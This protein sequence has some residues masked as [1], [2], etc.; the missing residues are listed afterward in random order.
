ML[1][2]IPEPLGSEQPEGGLSSQRG[3]A[4]ALLLR[5]I[6]NR[7]PPRSCQG[8][9][10]GDTGRC[11]RPVLGLGQWFWHVLL[12]TPDCRGRSVLGTREGFSD[13]F[14]A[15]QS[16]LKPPSSLSCLPTHQAPLPAGTAMVWGSP[17]GVYLL[18]ALRGGPCSCGH[19]GC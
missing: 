18:C 8:P 12:F 16:T 13:H 15:G 5:H 3:P 11:A 4:R 2:I 6:A 14:A 1:H 9:P 10:R 7:R 17:V 19:L